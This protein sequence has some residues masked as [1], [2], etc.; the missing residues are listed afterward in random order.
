MNV[1]ENHCPSCGKRAGLAKA[2]FDGGRTGSV[3][4]RCGW[5]KQDLLVIRRSLVCECGTPIGERSDTEGGQVKRY[6]CQLCSAA[7]VAAGRHDPDEVRTRYPSRCAGGCG[8]ALY[9]IDAPEGD[10]ISV[11]DVD[12]CWP[13]TP[14]QVVDGEGN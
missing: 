6:R 2:A 10:S 13:C 14:P 4:Q 9:W 1:N 5:S 3:C 8:T 12:Y 7:K 11:P